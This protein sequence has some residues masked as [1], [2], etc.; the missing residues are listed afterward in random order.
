MQSSIVRLAKSILPK[1]LNNF[2]RKTRVSLQTIYQSWID[3]ENLVPPQGLIFI[4]AGD[5]IKIGE[6][7]ARY[8]IELGQL[9]PNEKVLD[10]GCGIGRMALPLTKYMSQQGEYW[11]FDIVKDGINW[12]AKRYTRLFPNFNFHI[13]LIPV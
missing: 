6:E 2:L 4:G 9:E 5:F 1:P 8:F 11:G 10:V 7:F 3:P 12:C 13:G